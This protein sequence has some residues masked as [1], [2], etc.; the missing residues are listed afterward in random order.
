VLP[1]PDNLYQRP[2]WLTHVGG[3][4][5]AGK[6]ASMNPASKGWRA[7]VRIE[8]GWVPALSHLQFQIRILNPRYSS[9]KFCGTGFY[10]AIIAYE[11]AS[12]QSRI[13]VPLIPR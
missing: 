6:L 8:T 10:V 4:P 5:R 7:S 11:G 3:F 13:F 12:F 1:K 2:S 9:C